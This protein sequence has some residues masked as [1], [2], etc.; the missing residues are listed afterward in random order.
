VQFLPVSARFQ[1]GRRSAAELL[2]KE[3]EQQSAA[4]LVARDRISGI[5]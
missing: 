5:I 4:K 2:S 3:P 1:P